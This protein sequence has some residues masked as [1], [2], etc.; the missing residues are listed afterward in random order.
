MSASDC[1]SFKELNIGDVF[2]FAPNNRPRLFPVRA[3]PWEKISDR[4]YR[5]VDGEKVEI[6]TIFV[7]VMPAR[8]AEAEG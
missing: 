5:H 6:G 8:R 4:M 1:V 7:L 3:G 2:T